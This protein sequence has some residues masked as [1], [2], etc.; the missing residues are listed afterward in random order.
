VS[1]VISI[2]KKQA[3]LATLN[4]LTTDPI[5]LNQVASLQK[6][7]AIHWGRLDGKSS[8]RMLKLFNDVISGNTRSY[9]Q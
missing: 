2:K 3:F 6:E 7:N 9:Q 4:R 1:G 8:E 5:Y